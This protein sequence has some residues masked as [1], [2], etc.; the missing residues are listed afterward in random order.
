MRAAFIDFELDENLLVR[1]GPHH[2]MVVEDLVRER[3][4]RWEEL[5]L[6]EANEGADFV[7]RTQ[8]QTD[9]QGDRLWLMEW[10]YEHILRPILEW[11]DQGYLLYDVI[12]PY[13]PGFRPRNAM[14]HG[15]R[16]RRLPVSILDEVTVLPSW[17]G[18]GL[19]RLAEAIE[20]GEIPVVEPMKTR[21]LV[22]ELPS[23]FEREALIALRAELEETERPELALGAVV[24][25]RDLQALLREDEL[26]AALLDELE[27]EGRR[28][29]VEVIRECDAV[30]FVESL[31]DGP[32]GG[33]L[34]LFAHQD[35]DEKL[36]FHDGTVAM[37]RVRAE[38]DRGRS[39]LPWSSAMF[40]VC[41]AAEEQN[42]AHC[43]HLAGIPVVMTHGL[44]GFRGDSLGTVIF[45][46]R[47]LALGPAMSL[48]RL[49]DAT[50][51]HEHARHTR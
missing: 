8:I 36:H 2:H 30:R 33:T 45:M 24:R 19:Q 7:K 40:V 39:Q 25:D 47:R 1:V 49:V 42:L 27:K 46:L 38:L 50:M 34:I 14:W 21:I 29:G 26:I 9:L 23:A 13:L 17:G 3:N 48:P 10:E 31:S 11:W 51:Q 4:R 22:G 35:E 28:A 18:L 32:E 15:V 37:E 12:N 43:S 5:R 20:S 44:T 16:S 6:R 41:D